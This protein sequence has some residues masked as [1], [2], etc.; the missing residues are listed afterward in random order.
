MDIIGKQLP[1]K[2]KNIKNSKMIWLALGN[3]QLC[4]KTPRNVNQCY[5]SGY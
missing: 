5:I 2:Q 3:G 1:G 4:E